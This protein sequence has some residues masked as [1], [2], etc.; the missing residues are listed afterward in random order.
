MRIDIVTIFPEIARVPLSE[1]IMRRAQAKGA[2]DLRVHDLRHWTVDRH[3]R[4]DDEPFG[5]GPGMVMKPEPFFACVEELRG[6]DSRVLLMSPSGRRFDQTLARRFADR[7]HLILLC[8]HYEGVDQ[9]VI[10]ELVD[11]EVSLGDFILTNGAL[12]AAVIT[13]AVVRLLPGVL[14][15]AGSA[16]TESFGTNL[17]DWPQYTR[18]A[19]FRGLA[20]PEVLRGGDHRAIQAW[21]EQR[22]LELTR[23]KRPDL[24]DGRQG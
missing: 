13:D 2:L 21:R 10:D 14:G 12:A 20:V 6:P 3:R 7:P 11:E 17:L 5:G 19:E 4:T 23:R 16:V 22:A 18:P 24:L 9:R 8:G 1:S 15:D